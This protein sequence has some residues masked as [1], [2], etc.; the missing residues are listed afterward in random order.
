[1]VYV[2]KNNFSIIHIP[3]TGGSS[4]NKE[5][6]NRKSFLG[7]LVKCHLGHLTL[8]EILERK[9]MD[10][11]SSAKPEVEEFSL[12]EK[13]GTKILNEIINS[14]KISIVRHPV[15]RMVSYFNYVKQYESHLFPEIKQ[16]SFE[17]FLK[18]SDTTLSKQRAFWKQCD[19]IFYNEKTVDYIIRFEELKSIEEVF[20]KF[21]LKF[22]LKNHELKTDKSKFE[23]SNSALE[24]IEERYKE[25]FLKLGY[26]IDKFNI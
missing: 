7:P 24:L 6:F 3:K 1:M 12:D 5:L 20:K 16:I 26:E 21:G 9:S 23:L 2:K 8:K 18:I 22:T 13:Y 14:R 11:V 15:T 19:Y 10:F 4:I 25:D 17:E